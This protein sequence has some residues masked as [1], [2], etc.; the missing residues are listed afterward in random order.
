[1][2]GDI[3][4]AYLSPTVFIFKTEL[5]GNV[6]DTDCEMYFKGATTERLVIEVGLT[7]YICCYSSM[8]LST[9]YF[10]DFKIQIKF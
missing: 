8:V 7:L 10:T 6:V 2:D 3:I 1:M 4:Q 9:S 5:K